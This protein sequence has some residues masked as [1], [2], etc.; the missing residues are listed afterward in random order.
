M[1]LREGDN[2]VGRLYGVRG[3]GH[4]GSARALSDVP[5]ADLVAK[6][7]D[8][9]GTWPDPREA[10]A[11]DGAGE[12]GVL[13]EKA[14]SGVDGLRARALGDVDELRDIEVGVFRRCAAERERLVS[15]ADVRGIAIRDPRRRRWT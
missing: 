10:G 2:L 3:A 5:C 15:E 11:D 12:I 4:Q 8:S 9:V 14:V 13:S 6:R 7:L 1:L